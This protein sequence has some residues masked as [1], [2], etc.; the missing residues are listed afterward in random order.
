MR[1]APSESC[2]EL[3]GSLGVDLDNRAGQAIRPVVLAPRVGL[4]PTTLRL[5]DACKSLIGPRDVGMRRSPGSVRVRDG[6]A[7][8]GQN[9]GHAVAAR[10]L[11]DDQPAIPPEARNPSLGLPICVATPLNTVLLVSAYHPRYRHHSVNLS[12]KNPAAV[13]VTCMTSNG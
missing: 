10:R 7:R 11:P 1:N 6:A 3:G 4:E 9:C 5:T 8:C 13:I 12:P 2:S